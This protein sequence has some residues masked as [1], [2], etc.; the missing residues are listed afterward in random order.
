MKDKELRRV[1]ADARANKKQLLERNLKV[2]WT[3]SAFLC[4]T[5]TFQRFIDYYDA[6]KDNFAFSYDESKETWFLFDIRLIKDKYL[7]DLAPELAIVLESN[8]RL[9]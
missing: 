5:T 6:T 9:Y 8:K 1:L 3:R 2:D 4:S 7:D